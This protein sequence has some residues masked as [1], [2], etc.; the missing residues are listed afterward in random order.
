MQ[1]ERRRAS[2]SFASGTGAGLLTVAGTWLYLDSI[3]IDD[4][5]EGLIVLPILAV[6]CALV[7]VWLG[8]Q[9]SRLRHPIVCALGATATVIAALLLMEAA[10]D[11]GGPPVLQN[12][13]L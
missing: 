13:A 6:A 10:R 2:F 8:H 3:E 11:R 7:A 1:G 5:L 4:G 12:L 9:R